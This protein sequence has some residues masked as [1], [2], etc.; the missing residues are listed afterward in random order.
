M[1]DTSSVVAHLMKL[2]RM[3]DPDCATGGFSG[4][5]ERAGHDGGGDSDASIRG[6]WRPSA[7]PSTSHVQVLSSSTSAGRRRGRRP[8]RWRWR[9]A[10]RLSES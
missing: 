6:R 1:I 9:G 8:K 7:M 10:V 4:K 3:A 5:P 2:L